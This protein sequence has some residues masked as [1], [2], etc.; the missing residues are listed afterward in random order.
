VFEFAGL[1]IYLPIQDRKRTS[2]RYKSLDKDEIKK[3]KNPFM[4]FM[5][6]FL[7]K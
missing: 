3:V 6:L 4:K 2:P 1:F 7:L 5:K